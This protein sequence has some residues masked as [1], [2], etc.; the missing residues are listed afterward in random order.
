MKTVVDYL[1]KNKKYEHD[2]MD[3]DFE[4]ELKGDIIKLRCNEEEWSISTESGVDAEYD[5][6]EI[7]EEHEIEIRF[8]E[9]CGSP[10]DQ[11]YTTDCG[12]W[13][14]CEDCFEGAMDT[15]YGKG[16]WRGTDEEGIGGGF[17]EAMDEDGEWEDTGV[18]WTQWY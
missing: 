1:K 9:I 5:I 18:Y 12:G 6:Q 16:N 11:G 14:C 4:L 17:Y 7:L 13:Y 8:C 3:A 15:D 2:V 10:M